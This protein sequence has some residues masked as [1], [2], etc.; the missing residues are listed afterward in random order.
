MIK[1][2]LA[3]LYQIQNCNRHAKAEALTSAFPKTYVYPHPN[4][5]SGNVLTFLQLEGCFQNVLFSVTQQ[6][7]LWRGEGEV[8]GSKLR[9]KNL[10]FQKCP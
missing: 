2:V 7:F 8:K 4:E 3:R 6:F 10:C 9:R 1:R 5:N